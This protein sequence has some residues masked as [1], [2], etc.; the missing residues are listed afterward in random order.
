MSVKLTKIYLTDLQRWNGTQWVNLHAVTGGMGASPEDL[1]P[2]S[3]NKVVLF[4]FMSQAGLGAGFADEHDPAQAFQQTIDW[5]SLKV[6][7]ADGAGTLGWTIFGADPLLVPTNAVSVKIRYKLMV[8]DNAEPANV[9]SP[10]A[11][12]YQIIKASHPANHITYTGMVPTG[13]FTP[14]AVVRL[15]GITNTMVAN[16]VSLFS[17][18]KD[19]ANWR[20]T[21]TKPGG[22][23]RTYTPNNV[24]VSGT[25]KDEA[26]PEYGGATVDLTMNF[27]QINVA[28]SGNHKLELEFLPNDQ[29]TGGFHLFADSETWVAVVTA[30]TPSMEDPLMMS[31]DKT[32]FLEISFAESG[33]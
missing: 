32:L 20:L 26:N 1:G 12:Y 15:P 22:Q 31:F 3:G 29:Q 30:Y 25:N 7:I 19:V 2:S 4:P 28:H 23:T 17:W 11:L 6:Q 13:V 24:T 9:Y 27:P 33:D 5:D 10:N 14:I 8:H 18:M 21:W 16:S